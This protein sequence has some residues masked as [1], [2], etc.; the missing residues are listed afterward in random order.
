MKTP[1]EKLPATSRGVCVSAND[2]ASAAR[3]RPT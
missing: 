3:A 2:R 1:G